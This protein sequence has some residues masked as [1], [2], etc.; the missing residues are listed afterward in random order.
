MIPLS[1]LFLLVLPLSDYHKDERGPYVVLTLRPQLTAWLVSSF[2][3]DTTR[4]NNPM[5]QPY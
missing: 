2:L 4:D 5:S 1:L 3:W